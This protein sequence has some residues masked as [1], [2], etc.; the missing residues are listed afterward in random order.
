MTMTSTAQLQLPEKGKILAD[1]IT[2]PKRE[3]GAHEWRC[4]GLWLKLGTWKS[5]ETQAHSNCQSKETSKQA[6]DEINVTS[7]TCPPG[8]SWAV[9][10][11]VIKFPSMIVHLVQRTAL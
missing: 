10:W 8:S 2:E 3:G 1:I 7:K 9:E 4:Q 11:A 5:S 6:A